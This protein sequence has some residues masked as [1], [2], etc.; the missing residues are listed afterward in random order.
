VE[1]R[2]AIMIAL[3]AN[4]ITT[5]NSKGMAWRNRIETEIAGN[6]SGHLIHSNQFI[7]PSLRER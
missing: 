1:T 6:R 2:F 4:E 5:I 3:M 7:I